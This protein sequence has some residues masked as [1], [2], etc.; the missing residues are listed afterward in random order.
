MRYSYLTYTSAHK[1]G[2]TSLVEA[3]LMQRNEAVLLA[4]IDARTPHETTWAPVLW[5]HRYYTVILS[6]LKKIIDHIF[7]NKKMN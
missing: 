7:M 3:G 4:E 2:Y 5:A 6:L 1:T